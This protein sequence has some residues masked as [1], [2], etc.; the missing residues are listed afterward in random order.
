MVN[1]DQRGLGQGDVNYR[2]TADVVETWACFNRGGKN[3]SAAN[4]QDQ[5]EDLDITF[6]RTVDRNGRIR[7]SIT[8]PVPSPGTFSCPP[9]QDLRLASV[10][11][12]NIV[13]CDTTNDVCTSVPDASRT[14]FDV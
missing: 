8:G 11:Y 3:P 7:S 12:T 5:Q 6:T 1:W 13:L 10:S 2:L 9:G 14:F 4:K